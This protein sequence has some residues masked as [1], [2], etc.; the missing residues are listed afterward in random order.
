MDPEN[1]PQEALEPDA[2]ELE[3][4]AP[5]TEPTEGEEGPKGKAEAKPEKTPEQRALERA[6]RKIGRLVRQREELRAQLQTIPRLQERAIE[7]DNQSDDSDSETLTLSRAKLQEMV[8]AE[9]EK[10]APTLKQQRDE[11]EHQ[12]KTVQ[13]LAKTLGPER[14]S[15]LTDEL[16]TIFDSRKQ[17]FVLET[18]KP[19]AVLEY[20]TDPD[21]AD[22]AEAIAGMSDFR[23]GKAIAAIESKLSAKQAEDKPQPSKAAAP[24]EP[25]RGSGKTVGKVP[26]DIRAYME[27]AN[28]Q[29]GPA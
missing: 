27:W 20:L 26:T 11:I 8:K 2:G 14:F 23:A 4:A 18:E 25:A 17:M 24:L 19:A 16:A 21:N 7:G 12:R 5:E 15:E 3:Q 28:K 6:E 1:V 29:Y 10:L 9:A 22:E 13:S